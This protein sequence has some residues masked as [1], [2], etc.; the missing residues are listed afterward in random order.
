M[1]NNKYYNKTIQLII[2]AQRASD[3]GKGIRALPE[4]WA[5][6]AGYTAKP[7]LIRKALEIIDSHPRMGINYYVIE[8]GDQNGYPSILVYFEFKID[9]E[10]HQVSFH[11]PANPETFSEL[12]KWVGKGR[13]TRWNKLVGG[14]RQACFEVLE[15]LT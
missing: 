1:N 2:D 9:G 10:R 12:G 14:S 15:Y 7:I 3:G 6:V 13:P 5:T 11:N 4:N 8:E